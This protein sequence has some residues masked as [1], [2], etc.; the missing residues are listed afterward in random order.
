VE[1]RRKPPRGAAPKASAK[2]AAGKPRTAKAAARPAT[3]GPPFRKILIANRGEIAVRVMRTCHEMGISTVAVYSEAD[4]EALHVLHAREAYPIGPAP[5]AESYLRIDRIL[6]VARRTGAE[7]IH[8]GYGFLAENPAFARACR[9]AGIVFIGPSPEAMEALGDKVRARALMVAAGVPVTPGTPPLP[10]DLAEASRLARS[11]GYPLLLKAAAGGGGRGMRV[12]RREEDL[13][14]LLAQ[15]RGEARSAFGDD[16]VFI[17]KLVLRPRHVEV[18]ILADGKGRAIHIGERE[19]SIQ[20]RHQKLIEECPSPVVN[21]ATRRRIGEFAVDA[22]RA[23]GYSGAGTVEFL[24]GDDGSFFFMEVNAR[25]QVEHPV[26]EMVSGL[27]LV[28]AQIEI[29]AGGGLPVSQD[30][31]VLRGHAIECRI[32]AEDPARNFIP[33]PGKIRGLRVP[34]GPGVRH[35]GGTYAGYTVPVH[36]DAL[37]SKLVVWGRT[38]GEAIERMGRALDEYRVDGLSTS[39]CLHRKIMA[40]PAFARGELHTGFLEEYPDLLTPC[41]DPDLDEIAVLAA[42]VAHFRRLERTSSRAGSG[43]AASAG[44]AWKRAG[45][46]GWRR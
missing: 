4:R 18:Q 36:Y 22:A 6:E 43:E 34:S 11:I 16:R 45:R 9:D 2:G 17:E 8:P 25:L 32:I 15:A 26:T 3:A 20:R 30:E 46:K 19:C 42:A 39:I 23:S 38:R 41:E 7:A 13:P 28:R 10:E 35:D 31:V 21:E 5:A 37:L 40:H 33:S 1:G 24:R 27:D 14:S 29:A 12:V 44:S